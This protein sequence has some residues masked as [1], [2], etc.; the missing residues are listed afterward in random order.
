MPYICNSLT[1]SKETPDTTFDQIPSE[2]QSRLVSYYAANPQKHTTKRVKVIA[3]GDGRPVHLAPCNAFFCCS[4]HTLQ[5][6]LE[7]AS[8]IQCSITTDR[9]STMVHT[10]SHPSSLIRMRAYF[11]E[12]FWPLALPLLNFWI[13]CSTAW[14]IR[15]FSSGR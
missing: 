13:S 9:T 12:P 8:S 15:R 11:A 6:S 10:C 1:S 5:V 4:I 3:V 2:Q 14:S 7:S